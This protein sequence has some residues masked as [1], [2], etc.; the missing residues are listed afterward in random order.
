M[1]VPVRRKLFNLSAAVS[2]VLCA[3]TL[4]LWVRSHADADSV[5]VGHD[6]VRDGMYWSRDFG[7]MSVGGVLALISTSARE[8]PIDA[9]PRLFKRRAARGWR[10]SAGLA[11]PADRYRAEYVPRRTVL[12]RAGFSYARHHLYN[13]Y[14]ARGDAAFPPNAVWSHTYRT[15]RAGI[16]HWLVCGATALLPAVA[17]WRRRRDRLA[18]IA[19]G[20]CS[21]CGYDL[22]ASPERCPECGHDVP[23]AE[24]R[25][26]DRGAR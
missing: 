7:V 18:A 11:G 5:W 16:P 19:A 20:H 9:N 17:V 3:A 12:E 25:A 13:G 2:L 4:V 6:G 1:M 26:R 23:L 8:G 10:W 21:R 15:A 24:T 22:R 14:D